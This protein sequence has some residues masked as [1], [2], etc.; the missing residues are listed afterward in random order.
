LADRSKHLLAILFALVAS[1]AC[2]PGRVALPSGQGT[3]TGDFQQALAAARMSCEGVDTLQ[4][5]L[6]LSGRAAGQRVRGRIHA[7]FVPQALRLEGVAPFGSP[8]FIL[9][10]DGGRGTLLLVREQRVLRDAPPEDILDALIGVKLGPDDLRAVLSGCVKASVEASQARAYGPD[11]IAI[12]LA[13]D[14]TI[15]LRRQANAWRIVAG[16]YGGVEIDYTAFAGDRPSRAVLRGAQL[17]LAL[18]LQQVEIN[19]DLPR[20]RLV[21]V[22]IPAAA[23]PFTLDDLRKSGP[24]GQ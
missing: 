23:S 8:V 20:D 13:S 4:A 5:E 15:Y 21:A 18:S 14:G 7:G 12:D 10:A 3:P 1:T 19:G 2:G 9:V 17:D 16:R 6:G 22:T 11:W 24:L